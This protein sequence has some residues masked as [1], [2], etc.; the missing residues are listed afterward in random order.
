MGGLFFFWGADVRLAFCSD[1]FGSNFV[2]VCSHC[3][4]MQRNFELQQEKVAGLESKL[5]RA[6]ER[7]QQCEAVE[8]EHEVCAYM[9]CMHV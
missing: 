6:Q 5:A 4:L 3:R 2:L 9:L 1:V 7:L 8:L